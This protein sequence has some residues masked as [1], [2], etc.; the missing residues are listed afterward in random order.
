MQEF[1]NQQIT[2]LEQVCLLLGDGWHIDRLKS[3]QWR[4]VLR[5]PEY[6]H[7]SIIITCSYHQFRLLGVIGHSSDNVINISHSRTPTAISRD[8]RKRLLDGAQDKL[9]KAAIDREREAERQQVKGWF[10]DALERL[11]SVERPRYGHS[12]RVCELNHEGIGGEVQRYCYDN[13]K[14]NLKGLMMDE[15]IRLVGFISQL[16]GQSNV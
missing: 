7:Y 16:R 5:S 3:E 10:I 1:S 9:A 11:V 4:Q 13:Y 2:T 14:I 8:I 15:V 12:D 6:R